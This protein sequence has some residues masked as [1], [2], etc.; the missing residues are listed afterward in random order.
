MMSKKFTKGEWLRYNGFSVKGVTYLVLGNSYSIKDALK[1]AGFK[2]SPLLRWHAETGD[3]KLPETCSYYILNYDEV[4]EWDEETGTSFMRAGARDRIEQIFNPP[5]EISRSQYVGEVGE[6]LTD[7]PA[8]IRNI[9][10]FDSPYGY[11]WVYTFE[12]KNHNIY[13]WFTT[14]QQPVSLGRSVILSGKVKTHGEYKGART[15]QLTHCR[16]ILN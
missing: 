1:N 5:E 4:F 8:F 9:G 13:T 16:L 11:K 12:D 7:I 3:F 14:I 10:G 15:T 6:R 2:F